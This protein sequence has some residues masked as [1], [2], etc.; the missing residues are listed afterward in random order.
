[1][2]PLSDYCDE[3]HSSCR[4]CD[5]WEADDCL[6]C[7]AGSRVHDSDG[8]GDG[9]CCP[10]RQYYSLVAG[11]SDCHS[12]CKTCDYWEADD[13]LTCHPGSRLFDTDGDGDGHCCPAHQYYSSL[14]S[15]DT[16]TGGKWGCHDC[17][18]SCETCD[19]WEP[20]DCQSCPN[21]AWLYI[22]E[23][24]TDGYCC[25]DSC[26]GLEGSVLRPGFDPLGPTAWNQVHVLLTHWNDKAAHMLEHF[27]MKIA[28]EDADAVRSWTCG[29]CSFFRELEAISVETGNIETAGDMYDLQVVMAR[30]AWSDTTIIAVRGT[31]SLE[32]WVTNL[33]AVMA[34]ALSPGSVLDPNQA[35]AHMG[36]ST[37]T[38]QVLPGIKSYL[39]QHH[40][41]SSTLL[42]TGH[43]M[44]SAVA[45][46][47]AYRLKKEQI[48]TGPMA[49]V[50]FASPRAGNDRF[51]DELHTLLPHSFWRVT[52]P[53][54]PVTAVPP[55]LMGFVHV[56]REIFFHQ[57]LGRRCC[58]AMIEDPGCSVGSEHSDY[59]MFA[60]AYWKW[61]HT[62]FPYMVTGGRYREVPSQG[63]EEVVSSLPPA[64]V[65]LPFSPTP[66][67]PPA[68]PPYPPS[69]PPPLPQWPPQP[70]IQPRF[71]GSATTRVVIQ[72]GGNLTIDQGATLNVG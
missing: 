49:A 26:P 28:Y 58:H 71:V 10:D 41:T 21:S 34:N 51:A 47:I 68:Q 53:D 57:S 66:P 52:R 43:S 72:A 54:D 4:T 42:L 2:W 6:T 13:C 9:Y 37:A 48:V 18:S 44:G 32:N 35:W 36:F 45:T 60:K 25:L 55:K 22:P 33:G 15:P 24:D 69:L 20:D 12:S 59:S 23:G 64:N 38:F 14:M 7:H 70:P 67:A 8:D 16:I 31:V 19:Y 1:M 11:C 27:A 61:Q 40:R 5:Y 50:V 30:D 63:C 65:R 17:H 3:C 62:A 56:G 46:I 39:D 29:P